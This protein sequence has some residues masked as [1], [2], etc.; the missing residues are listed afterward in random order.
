MLN[1]GLM[2]EER[3]ERRGK[4]GSGVYILF[5]KLQGCAFSLIFAEHVLVLRE[6]VNMNRDVE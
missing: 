1:K 3:R 5:D 4:K 2:K 6:T